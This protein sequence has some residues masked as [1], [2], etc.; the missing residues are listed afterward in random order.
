[1][2]KS[3]PC[4]RRLGQ[5]VGVVEPGHLLVP[6]LGVQAHQL[7]VRELVDEGQRVP[8]GGQQDVAA[9]LVGL[10]LD[11][12]AEVVALV[13][14]VVAE[15]VE[16]LAV[17]VERGLHVLGRP[18]LGTLAPA[19]G[20]EHLRAELGGE[21]HLVEGLADREA[22]DVAVVVG[23]A[24]VAEDRVREQVGRH[25]RDHQAGLLERLAERRQ[26]RE[27]LGGRGAERDDVV[28]VEGDAVRAQVGEPVHRLRRVERRPDGAPEDV[29]ALPA[30]GPQA[31]REAVVSR[32]EQAAPVGGGHADLSSFRGT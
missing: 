29:D 8:D 28:V 30:H 15:Q 17:A 16:G 27:P 23:E 24:A 9:G 7:R 5:A 10:G 3:L 19:P 20:H 6:R 31:E 22:A 25:H 13:E 4:H 1:M 21:V 12:E 32:R 11:R 2:W 18:R 26:P 14:D